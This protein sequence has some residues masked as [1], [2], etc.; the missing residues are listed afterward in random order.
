METD[1]VA[2]TNPGDGSF[3]LLCNPGQEESFLTLIAQAEGYEVIEKVI[4]ISDG[5]IQEVNFF[6]PKV[7]RGDVNGDGKIDV[8]DVILI[9]RHIVG[10]I[11]IAEEYGAAAL[12]RAKVSGDDDLS[13]A[14]AILLLRYIVGLV[15]DF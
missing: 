12:E 1:Q 14:D 11:D 8:S 13:V 6:L 15:D 7:S 2:F 4:Q 3:Y 10:I 9:L 5:E